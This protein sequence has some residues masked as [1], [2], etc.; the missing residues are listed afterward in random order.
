M[1]RSSESGGLKVAGSVAGIILAAGKG[2]RMKSDLPKGLH[3]VG[4]LP[5][6]EWVGRAMRDAGVDRPV[7]VIG[8]GGEQLMEALGD[9]YDYVWQHEQLGTGHAAL[10]ARDVLQGHNGPI[11]IAPGDAPLITGETF[12]ALISAHLTQKAKIT[13]M[14][15]VLPDA[16]A[17][18]RIVRDAGGVAVKIVEE[19]DATAEQKLI[20][21]VN[22]SLYIFDRTELFQVLPALKNSNAQGEYYLTDALESISH[23]GGKVATITTEDPGAL[24]GVND[25]W[26]LAE[27]DH[28]LNFRTIRRHALAGVT[29]QNFHTVRIEPDVRIGVDTVIEGSTHL[30]GK[31]SVGNRA[32]LGPHCRIEN[33]QI[34]DDSVVIM[35]HL[36]DAVVGQHVWCGPFAN[37]RPGAK[38]SDGVK[39]GNFVEI[40]RSQ[41][42]EGVKVSHLSYIGDARVGAET[43][44]G[45]GTIT[46]N[47]DGYRKHQTVIGAEVFI[48]SQSTLVAPVQIGDGA[49]VAAGSV[50]TN[51]VSA[52]AGAFGRARQETKEK[53]AS[54][55]R[56]KKQSEAQS[57]AEV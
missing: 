19:R 10:M 49:I 2:T 16:R 6:V 40:N 17:Y 51:D 22:V 31:T 27:A 43:N 18:G 5:M 57:K 28:D 37:L 25:R 35:S 3:R 9:G 41:L 24:V 14:T 46:C 53:W 54:Q 56:A 7:V 38:L 32:R 33:S 36:Q 45:A 34:G 42:S 8:H 21:E 11:L 48:G 52:D 26:Q 4:G 29:I 47:Y 13:A 15:A 44:I 20:R 30:V 1:Q 39:I 23:R 50:I 12:L 55:W